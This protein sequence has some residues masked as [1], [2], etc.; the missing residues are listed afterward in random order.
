MAYLAKKKIKGKD[1]Y[2]L[3]ESKRI[4]GKPRHTK[5]IYLGSAEDVMERLSCSAEIQPPLYTRGLELGSVAAL[6]DLAQ[7]LEVVA[8]IDDISGKRN[9][10]LSTGNYLLLA[11]LNRALD[12]VSKANLEGWYHNT[13][14]EKWIPCQEGALS[15][16]RF[17]DNTSR[18]D[19]AKIEHFETQFLKKIA[20]EYRISPKC[21][22]YDA[23]NFFTYIDT[24]NGKASLAQRGHSKEKRND[25]KI[26]SLSLVFSKD[27]EIP[28]FYDVYQGNRNDSQEFSKAVQRLKEKYSA[29]FGQEAEVTLIFDRGN[30]SEENIRML[31]ESGVRLEYVGGLK[32]NQCGDLYRKPKSTYTKAVS[33]ELSGVSYYR[34]QMEIY[35]KPHIVVITENPNLEN[36]Q[37]QGIRS[38]EAKCRQQIEEQIEKL[39]KRRN[40]E[41]KG[42]KRPTVESITKNMEKIL[43]GEY[44]KTLFRYEINGEEGEI[45]RLRYEYSEEALEKL[46]EEELGK[47]VLFTSQEGWESEEIIKAYR[48]AWK[49]EHAFRQMKDSD[50]LTVRPLY[51]WT[52]SKIKVH[53]FCCVMAL[54]LCCI[55]K[56]ELCKKGIHAGVNEMLETLGKKKQ[57]IH[58]YQQKRGL[59]E[60]YSSSEKEIKTEKM[61]QALCLEKYE[62]KS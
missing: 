24:E 8:L 30:N 27:D 61:I 29:V 26:V 41:I 48:S 49:L 58:Y 33:K 36:G 11:M 15:S 3:M 1:Y 22:I 47:T 5:Q 42:G 25:L 60:V 18:W 28:L 43:H 34:T 38:H 39:E 44:M 45:P 57:Y 7:R 59:K 46:R 40:K 32:K 35:G 13:M 16:Q 50:Y 20:S 23:T 19:D 2:Y 56:N 51:C 53:I 17:W 4:N 14:L 37:L 54:R 21:L 62:I 31:S 55:L 52:D 12:P 10:G 6:F 9:Q